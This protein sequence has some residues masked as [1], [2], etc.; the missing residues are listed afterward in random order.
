MSQGSVAR[1]G[2]DGDAM[3]GGELPRGPSAIEDKRLR[4]REDIALTPSA[5]VNHPWF[6]RLLVTLL[7]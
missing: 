1:L 7:G 4:S 6:R 5:A 2:H 3:I